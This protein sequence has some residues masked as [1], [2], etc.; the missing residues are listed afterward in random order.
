MYEC[1]IMYA[2]HHET[3]TTCHKFFRNPDSPCPAQRP[4]A[5]V[6]HFTA[7]WNHPTP[8]SW[9]PFHRRPVSVQRML[10][11]QRL[12]TNSFHRNFTE[13]VSSSF[14]LTSLTSSQLSDIR[15]ASSQ[16]VRLLQQAHPSEYDGTCDVAIQ[17]YWILWVAMSSTFLQ[18]PWRRHKRVIFAKHK[19]PG[20]NSWHV[21]M[22]QLPVT[23]VTISKIYLWQSGASSQQVLLFQNVRPLFLI[24]IWNW[25]WSHTQSCFETSMAALWP[26]GF[27]PAEHQK[28]L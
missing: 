23:T 20:M 7:N 22:H 3:V 2:Y 17:S 12:G 25:E 10:W 4:A 14:T 26:Y 6:G 21:D 1:M 24:S 11:P 28:A 18:G 16:K 8:L 19:V 27:A 9:G 13:T 15:K 5:E